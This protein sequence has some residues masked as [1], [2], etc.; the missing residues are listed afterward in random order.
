MGDLILTNGQ[1]AVVV[2]GLVV[3]MLGSLLIAVIVRES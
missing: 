2:G 1:A 3:F